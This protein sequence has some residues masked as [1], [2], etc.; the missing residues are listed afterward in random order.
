[1]NILLLILI[2]TAAAF[3]QSAAGY[4][5]SMVGLSL[6]TFFMPMRTGSVIAVMSML[7]LT[8]FITLKNVRK[9]NWRIFIIPFIT[10]IL[11][12][13][14]GVRILVVSENSILL[15][16]LGGVLVLLSLFSILTGANFRIT[17]TIPVQIG[18]GL[19]SGLLSGLFT[20]GGPPMAMY[21]LSAS[22]DKE[23]YNSTLQT[24]FLSTTLV[25]LCTHL[26]YGNITSE[27]LEYSAYS[28]IE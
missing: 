7:P 17:P 3:V 24:F 1:M 16:I 15:K 14:V 13:Q 27:A 10:S 25:A 12:T 18:A 2:I 5:F 19:I 4:G 26:F 6:M 11:A 21:M 8:L 9:V 28:L 22:A 20:M 23:E